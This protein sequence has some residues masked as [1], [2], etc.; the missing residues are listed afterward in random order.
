MTR[1]DSPALQA[2]EDASRALRGLLGVVIAVERRFGSQQSP[3]ALL[4][5]I[6][7]DPQWAWLRPLY[8]L[9]ADVDHAAHDG[10]LP[11]SEVAAIGAHALALLSGVGAPLEQAFL[12]RYR[13]LLQT[14][15]EVAIAHATAL[16]A[17]RKLP[18]EA[19]TE[20]ERLHARHQWAMRCKHRRQGPQ[21]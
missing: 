19:D 21:V 5:R 1:S 12:E 18:P 13:A 20:A 7:E 17:I 8:Q 3:L 11:L 9:I 14:D 15:P 4:R 2:L 6:M 10:D 16:Q